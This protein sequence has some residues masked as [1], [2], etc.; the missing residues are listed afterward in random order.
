MAVAW[1]T[2]TAYHSRVPGVCQNHSIHTAFLQPRISKVPDNL[3]HH[4]QLLDTFDIAL[5]L[6]KADLHANPTRRN[7]DTAINVSIHLGKTG[8]TTYLF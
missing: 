2:S 7:F 6:G 5:R 8:P 1:E 3:E 4:A